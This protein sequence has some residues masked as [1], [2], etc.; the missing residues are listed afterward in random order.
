MIDLDTPAPARPDDWSIRYEVRQN[1]RQAETVVHTRNGYAFLV[2]RG[3]KAYGILEEDVVTQLVPQGTTR[4]AAVLDVEEFAV[5]DKVVCIQGY[6][7]SAGDYG[8]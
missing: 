8:F 2:L 3:E 1:R 5:E 7:D 6:A 4:T